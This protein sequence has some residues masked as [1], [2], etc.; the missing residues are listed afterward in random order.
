MLPVLNFKIIINAIKE[1][2]D[3]VKNNH[4]TYYL[5]YIVFVLFSFHS[6]KKSLIRRKYRAS[7][8]RR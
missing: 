4:I 8:K 5:R 6:I 3:E 2:A 7:A 1:Y